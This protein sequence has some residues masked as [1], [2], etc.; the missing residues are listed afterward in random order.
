M[1]LIVILSSHH[2]LPSDTYCALV[3]LPSA[4]IV[5]SDLGLSEASVEEIP[6]NTLVLGRMAP[7]L[8]RSQER[9]Q[10]GTQG[11]ASNRLCLI[12]YL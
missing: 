1:M 5:W 7:G 10:S 8:Q 6:T 11:Q 9:E 4:F 3:G 12:H 2:S